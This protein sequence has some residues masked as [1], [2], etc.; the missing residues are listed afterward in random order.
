MLSREQ[1]YIRFMMNCQR[2]SEKRGFKSSII[3]KLLKFFYASICSKY[4]TRKSNEIRKWKWKKNMFFGACTKSIYPVRRLIA[5]PHRNHF[6]NQQSS[7][8]CVYGLFGSV[9]LLFVF[10]LCCVIFLLLFTCMFNVYSTIIKLRFTVQMRHPTYNKYI[11]AEQT[12][13]LS[14]LMDLFVESRW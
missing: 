11:Q 4:M 9:F 12:F 7:V 1:F 10:L 6:T 5:S 3:D 13:F 2:W 14:F 8:I